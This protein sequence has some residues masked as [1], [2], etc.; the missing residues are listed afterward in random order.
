MLRIGYF[1]SLNGLRVHLTNHSPAAEGKTSNYTMQKSRQNIDFMW[2][3]QMDL[4]C[5][6]K[7]YHENMT[8]LC[9]FQLRRRKLNLIRKKHQTDPK[10]RNSLFKRQV[11][12]R[13]FKDANVIKDQNSKRFQTR[14]KML[15]RHDV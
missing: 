4:M 14:Q 7:Y 9:V 1:H 12:R 15:K 3:S 5:P 13:S 11:E 10:Q 8:S 6:Q 2:N